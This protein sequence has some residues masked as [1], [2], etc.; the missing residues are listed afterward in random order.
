MPIPYNDSLTVFAPKGDDPHDYLEVTRDASDT[1]PLALKN[2]DNKVVGGV[3]SF[4]AVK[5]YP[6]LP[7]G[8]NEGLSLADRC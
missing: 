2:A 8:C 3:V 6:R 7:T 1:R 4:Y 5:L